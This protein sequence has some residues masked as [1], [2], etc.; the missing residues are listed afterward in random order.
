M[1]NTKR[2]EGPADLRGRCSAKVLQCKKHTICFENELERLQKEGIIPPIEWYLL[3]NVTL[4]RC[5][6]MV[7]I[8]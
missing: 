5:V 7:I 2:C 1:L 3:L 8:R 6:S 4:W